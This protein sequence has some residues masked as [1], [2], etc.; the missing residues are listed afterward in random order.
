M[1]MLSLRLLGIENIWTPFAFTVGTTL[2]SVETYNLAQGFYRISIGRYSGGEYS[3]LDSDQ[4]DTFKKLWKTLQKVDEDKPYLEYALSQFDR[5]FDE[6]S[7]EI[8]LIDYITALESIVFGRVK[9]APSPFGR[10]IGIA[11]GMLTG[12]TEKQ[13]TEIEQKLNKAYEIRN[14][15]VHG[16]LHQKIG[17]DDKHFSDT[18]SFVEKCLK[19]SLIKLLEE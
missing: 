15:V 17:K 12:K 6:D 1:V 8:K 7:E 10:V 11:I 18:V 19:K 14:Q 16:H 13:R 5:S 4:V 9:N 2:D 3:V